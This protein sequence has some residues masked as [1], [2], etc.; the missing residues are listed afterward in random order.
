MIGKGETINV[1]DRL[2]LLKGQWIAF[3]MTLAPRGFW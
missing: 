1:G 2:M 3:G